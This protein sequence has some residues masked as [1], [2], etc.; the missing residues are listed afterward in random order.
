MI[1]YTILR[2]VALALRVVDVALLHIGAAVSNAAEDITIAARQAG[3]RSL[4][5]RVDRAIDAVH[6]AGLRL[7]VAQQLYDDANLAAELTID[8]VKVERAIILRE[9]I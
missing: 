3:L 2:R 8:E 7:D 4:D 1:Q 9:V 5:K 6:A